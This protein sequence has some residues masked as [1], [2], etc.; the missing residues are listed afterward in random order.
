MTNEHISAARELSAEYGDALEDLYRKRAYWQ[1]IY[2]EQ[3]A[4]PSRRRNIG[5]LHAAEE[6]ILRYNEAILPY[7]RPKFQAI[8]HTGD[9]AV[10]PMVIRVPQLISDSKT[11]LETH[12]PKAIDAPA[13]VLPFAQ[14]LKKAVDIADDL[15]IQDVKKI[16]SEAKKWTDE[17]K[18]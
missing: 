12:R 2:D 7:D 13:A 10:A 11:W 1:A 9:A 15:G 14:N 5:K 16:V 6:R 17:D 3:I 8:N 4:K 18:Q